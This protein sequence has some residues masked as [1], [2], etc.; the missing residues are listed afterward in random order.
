[1][2]KKGDAEG[3][4]LVA[5]IFLFLIIVLFVVIFKITVETKE[6]VINAVEAGDKYVTLLN[7]LKTEIDGK[8]IADML[9][10]GNINNNFDDADKKIDDLLAN[11]YAEMVFKGMLVVKSQPDDK[12][13]YSSDSLFMKPIDE[14]EALPAAVAKIPV[15][16]E[17]YLEVYLY[18]L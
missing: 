18:E 17:N 8:D 14:G 10:E 15:S 16:E 4:V 2:R 11:I 12:V 3:T 5:C 9:V 7:I 1:M 13:T 6:E